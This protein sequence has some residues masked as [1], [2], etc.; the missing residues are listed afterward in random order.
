LSGDGDAQYARGGPAAFEKWFNAQGAYLKASARQAPPAIHGAA[1]VDERAI[2]TVRTPVLEKYGY[3]PER[4]ASEGS[5]AEKAFLTEEPPPKVA[6]AQATLHAYDDRV[7]QYGGSPPA[8]DV[9]FKASAKAKPCCK[10][11]AAQEKG[12]EKVVSSGFDPAVLKKH[13]NSDSFS[14]PRE[15]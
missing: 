12:F 6:R 7:C 4:I 14:E 15:T 8:A 3:D 1:V 10:A 2:R 5:P 11:V 9:T 13:I